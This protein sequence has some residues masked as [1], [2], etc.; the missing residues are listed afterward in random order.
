MRKSDVRSFSFNRCFHDDKEVQRQLFCSLPTQYIEVLTTAKS[1]KIM[2]LSMN[3]W[4]SFVH[5]LYLDVHGRTHQQV[6]NCQRA[7]DEILE[8]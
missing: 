1:L 4:I 5:C 6:N 3:D 2:F 7:S 8:I